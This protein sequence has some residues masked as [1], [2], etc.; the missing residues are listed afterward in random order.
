LSVNVLMQFSRMFEVCSHVASVAFKPRVLPFQVGV[1]A[2]ISCSAS[3]S[4]SVI[5]QT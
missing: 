1:F 5:A 2:S 4:A 3:S